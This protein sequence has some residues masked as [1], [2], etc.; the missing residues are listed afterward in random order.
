MTNVRITVVYD[1]ERVRDDLHTGWG[2]S[3]VVGGDVLF[4]TGG[5][6]PELL[7]NLATLGIELDELDT[8]V[9]S[10]G[11][12]DHTGGLGGVLD[13]NPDVTVVVPTER[14]AGSVRETG[15]PGV[16][17]TVAAD[18]TQVGTGVV[19]TGSVGD[20]IR[21][22]G[23][24]C[25]FRRGAVLVT[26]CAHPGLDALLDAAR[27]AEA[28]TGVIGGFHDFARLRELEGLDLVSPCHCTRRKREIASRFPEA[29][30]RCGAGLVVD[31]ELLGRAPR[32]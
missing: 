20:S 28:V 24:V 19:T 8:V 30:V 26:G 22:Q 21:E 31:E 5:D 32:C 3:A 4:D 12:A 27:D 23:I 7:D 14:L 15:P 2:F 25:R 17:V 6:T 13:Q 16:E 1:N 18:P 29:F 10:H 11:H 9:L